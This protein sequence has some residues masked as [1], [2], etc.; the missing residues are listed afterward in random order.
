[1][2]LDDVKRILVVGAGSMGS[3]IA[4]QAAL[5]DYAVTLNDLSTEILGKAMAGNRAQLERRVAKGQLPKEQMEAALARVTLE[6]DLPKA[7]RTADV[8]I[9]AIIE[10]LE[11]K[12]QCFALLDQH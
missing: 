9:E 2:K 6:T 5:H 10:R 11:P 8:A 1:M 7:A 3:Q 12:R 4:M